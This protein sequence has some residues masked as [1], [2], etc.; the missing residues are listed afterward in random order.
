MNATRQGHEKLP[1]ESV[2]SMVPL[3]ENIE[4]TQQRDLRRSRGD[5]K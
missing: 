5:A 4:I 1:C 2:V 3:A